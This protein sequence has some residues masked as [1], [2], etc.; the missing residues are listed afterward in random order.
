[1]QLFVD[2]SVAVKWFVPEEDSDKA[3]ALLDEPMVLSAPSLIVTEVANALWKKYRAG[4]VARAHAEDAIARLPRFFREILPSRDLVSA[5]M[6]LAIMCDHPLYDLIYLEAAR[7]RGEI[8][9]TA[10][11]RF[12]AKVGTH[13]A[14]THL[15]SLK[16]WAP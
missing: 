15:V 8:L 3:F 5:S 7:R 1:V 16:D 6:S 12:L 14:A 9:V 13:P 4:L 10:D 2:A 11:R